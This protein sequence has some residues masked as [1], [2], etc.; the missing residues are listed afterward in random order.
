[1]IGLFRKIFQRVLALFRPE[2]V[3]EP[4]PAP[5][6]APAGNRQ[7]RRRLSALERAR[8]KHDKFITPQG[9]PPIHIHKAHP[10]EVVKSEPKPEPIIV[11]D[12]EVFIADR[13][14]TG[15]EENVLYRE[16]EFYG[17]YNFRDTILE[18]LERYFIYLRRMKA[19]DPQ[20]YGLYKELGA[21]I[22]PYSAVS[23]R[24]EAR[25]GNYDDKPWPKEIPP[26]PPFFNKHRPAFGC[27][28]Y[29]ANP[30]SEKEELDESKKG[31]FK[32]ENMW[33]CIP[34]FMYFTKYKEPPPE[35]QPM[36]GGDI[37]LMTI[38]WDRPHDPDSKIAK[39]KG[40]VPEEYGV[41]ISTDGKEICILRMIE[42][43]MV[44]VLAK[45]KNRYFNIPQRAWRI[46]HR[47][48]E[49]AERKGLDAQTFLA[50]LFV[51]AARTFERS[52]YSMIRVEAKK[53]DMTAVFSVN[54]R[55]MAYFFRDRDYV[56]S[57]SGTR[58]AVFHMVRAHKRRTKHGTSAIRFHFR[59]EHEFTWAG[60]QVSVTVPGRDH[61]MLPEVD[62]GFHD[63]YWL[64]ED[65][66][67][68]D[69]PEVGKMI[70][71]WI[72]EGVGGKK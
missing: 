56:L 28:V 55:R 6:P 8:R 48:D 3:S 53:E 30:A 69:A 37:Y 62:I 14:H 46:P 71:G 60:Y 9:Q 51:N 64:E 65:E 32:K 31:K 26:L 49:W 27:Y 68:M 15:G 44:P 21:T 35:M 33:L 25:E 47:Y 29:G 13:H 40:G 23:V 38:W 10:E 50:T 1:M 18:Q 19:N 20:S 63:G 34:K 39:R 7:Q 45:G 24:G 52:N 43:K 4:A 41:F 59:G 66:G 16:T 58:K 11:D 70:H 22:L 54:V 72:K 57:P 2:P 5:A 67:T 36:S 17:E 61:L 12:K 42:T